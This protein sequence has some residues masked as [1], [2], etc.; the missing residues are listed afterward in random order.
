[1]AP[2]RQLVQPPDIQP[3][4]YGLLDTVAVIDSSEPHWQMGVTYETIDCG[5]SNIAPGLCHTGLSATATATDDALTPYPV[6]LTFTGDGA[7]TVDWGD[8]STPAVTTSPASHDYAATDE[9]TI[10]L[11][12]EGTNTVSLTIT[13]G[14][15]GTDSADTDL[16]IHT[17]GETL[18]DGD[19]VGIYSLYSCN[20]VGQYQ[21]AEATAT[22]LLTRGEPRAFERYFWNSVLAGATDLSG[23]TAL[24]PEAGLATLEDWAAQQYGGR[25][26]IHATRRTASLLTST[27]A[28]EIHGNTLQS[29]LGSLIA[30]GGGYSL[31]N[32]GP[33]GSDAPADTSW[34]YASGAVIVR[35]GVAE[36]HM[37]PEMATPNNRFVALAERVYVPTV[38]CF[39]AAIKVKN[40][41]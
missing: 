7:V 33:D 10:V 26:V 31:S 5:V 9:V 28:A 24:V 15:Q 23:S 34:L 39:T 22:N 4:P 30:A 16:K 40:T 21:N 37:A 2:S 27:G 11:T 32:Q 3:L 20:L 6:T 41:N 17:E 35:R 29:G 14:T 18:V 13:P 12:D 25:P 36:V 19:P 8:D 1:M 38:E